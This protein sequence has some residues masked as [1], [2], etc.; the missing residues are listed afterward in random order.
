MESGFDGAERT[1]DMAT[2]CTCATEPR[3]K[4]NC[5]AAVLPALK[6]KLPEAGA[7]PLKDTPEMVTFKSKSSSTGPEGVTVIGA[8][9][10][11][12]YQ[13]PEERRPPRS[14]V[15]TTT[16]LMGAVEA[17]G[18]NWGLGEEKL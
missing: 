18:T 13:C 7:I 8:T 14:R 10:S 6:W 17:R 2:C 5:C 3:V 1:N 15:E 16:K 4:E 9:A 12:A 11:F